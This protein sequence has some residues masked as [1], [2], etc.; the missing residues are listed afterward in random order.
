MSERRLV[1]FTCLAHALSLLG[2][3]AYSALLPTFIAEWTLSNTEAGWIGGIYYGGYMASVP[4]LT[5]L[6]DRIDGRRIYLFGT[7]LTVAGLSGFALFADGFWSALAFRL[8]AGVGLGG[9]YMPGLKA[10]SDRLTGPNQPRSVSFY[11]ATFG[12]G[13]SISFLLAGE[14][15]AWIGWR[16][17]FAVGAVGAALAFAI[18]ALVLR[19]L[20]PRAARPQGALLDFRPVARNRDAMG[21]VL[22]YAAHCWE[23]FAMREW[24]VAFLAYVLAAHGGGAAVLRP[25]LVVAIANFLGTFSSL[26]GNEISMRFDRRRWVSAYMLA[27]ALLSAVIGFTA[28]LPYAAVAAL[29][30]LFGALVSLDSASLTVGALAAV[31]PEQRG[32]TMAV[33]S[34]LGFGAGFLGPLVVGVA[35]DAA[36]GPSIIGWGLGFATMGVAVALGPLALALLACRRAD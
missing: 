6:T 5:A 16:W 27:S 21:Y 33:H 19:P 18:V 20:A 17:S 14:I 9:T 25:T 26:I 34:T 11:T 32:A 4:V 10:L 35:L 8:I 31:K 7:G 1:W 12:M 24:M 2:F 28:G 3:A 30:L 23:L 22:A 13:V 29:C 15:G 36:G